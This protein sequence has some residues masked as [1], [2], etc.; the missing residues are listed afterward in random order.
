MSDDAEDVVELE[1]LE[2][3]KKLAIEEQDASVAL[4][5]SAA[6]VRA[7]AQIK[8]EEDEDEDSDVDGDE[9]IEGVNPVD[10]GFI[11]DCDA[12]LLTSGHF[13]SKVGGKPVRLRECGAAGEA[14]GRD[15]QQ[16]VVDTCFVLLVLIVSFIFII[17]SPNLFSTF[18]ILIHSFIRSYENRPG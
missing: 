18:L 9:E 13:P 5:S 10:L 2:E 8:Y 16:V 7:P 14:T 4:A 6:I 12:R 17:G 11:D 1:E 15:T 3:V